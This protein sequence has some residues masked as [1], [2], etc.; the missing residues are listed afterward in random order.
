MEDENDRFIEQMSNSYGQIE[1]ALGS[2]G[3]QALLNSHKESA[4]HL[5]AHSDQMR[6]WT[7]MIHMGTLMLLLMSIP[8][9]VWLWKWALGS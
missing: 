5:K 2:E 3:Y 9:L 1:A 8:A 6:A 4:M 7:G